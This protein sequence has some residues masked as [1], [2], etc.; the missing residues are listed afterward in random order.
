MGEGSAGLDLHQ[1]LK[2]DVNAGGL[3]VLTADIWS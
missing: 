1:C 3:K 2:A